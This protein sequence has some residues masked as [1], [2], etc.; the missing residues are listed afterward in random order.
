LTDIPLYKTDQMSSEQI[1]KAKEFLDAQNW[2]DID[3]DELTDII[4]RMVKENCDLR[5][6][7][8]TTKEGNYYK[9]KNRI[10]CQVRLWLRR[11]SLAL[12]ALRKVKT[13]KGCRRLKEKIEEAELELSKSMFKRKIEEENNAINKMKTYPKH[14]TL[15]LRKKQ[16]LKI[17]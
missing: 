7:V 12:K 14:F 5:N 2:D 3:A 4:K 13:I 9:S 17:K 10:P 16:N 1:E 15:I 11:K 8:K 6:P